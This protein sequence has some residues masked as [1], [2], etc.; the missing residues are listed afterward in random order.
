MSFTIKCNECNNETDVEDAKQYNK[1]MV[2]M[3]MDYDWR[4][5]DNISI[6][7]DKCKQELAI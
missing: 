7:C 6:V 5:G 4:N 2:S 3:L 1:D